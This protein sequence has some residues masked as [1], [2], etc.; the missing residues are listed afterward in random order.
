MPGNKKRALR[1]ELASR[2]LYDDAR[3]K[4]QERKIVA[5]FLARLKLTHYELRPGERPDFMIS[6]GN[7]VL[8]VG[9]ELTLFNNDFASGQQNIG[10]PERRFHSLWNYFAKIL[11]RRLDEGGG[12]LPYLYGA[13]FFKSPGLDL[14]DQFDSQQLVEEIVEAVKKTHGGSTLDSFDSRQ[15]PLLSTFVDHLYLRDCR[16]E[17]GL[18]WWCAHLQSGKVEDPNSALIDIVVE[19]ADKGIYYDWRAATERWLLIYAAGT[20]LA[21]LA[22]LSTDPEISTCVNNLPFTHV[23]LWN[24]WSEDIM[25]LYPQF[26]PILS[27]GQTLFVNRVPDA[28]RPYIAEGKSKGNASREA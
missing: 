4:E 12:H 10:S 5:G 28:V 27:R 21:D 22:H 1:E 23:F 2:H 9:C 6:F 15:F 24:K 20:G 17:T 8:L 19:K 25:E 7:G 16:P 11:R 13:V 18:L 3:G 14:F 26:R